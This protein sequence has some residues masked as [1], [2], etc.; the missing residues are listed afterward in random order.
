MQ[1]F[2]STPRSTST[3]MLSSARLRW[4]KGGTG[5]NW[6]GATPVPMFLININIQF[7]QQSTPLY[8][9]GGDNRKLIIK[10]AP[11]GTM[12]C[13]GVIVENRND[14]L[15]F[16]EAV[17]KS[18]K[19]ESDQVTM[20]L[21]PATGCEDEQDTFVYTLTGVDMD[22]LNV[23]IQGGQQGVATINQRLNFSF[24]DMRIE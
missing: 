4:D 15:E 12:T 16:I 11:V 13:D 20:H 7:Q 24:T 19:G 17:S 5:T 21:H 18:C 23:S 3:I 2:N 8:S 1:I 6:T 10:G 9:I 14:L 22:A